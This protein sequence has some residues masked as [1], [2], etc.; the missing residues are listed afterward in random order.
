MFQICK[1]P[2]CLRDDAH[3]LNNESCK[4]LPSQPTLDKFLKVHLLC[5]KKKKKKKKKKMSLEY[6]EQKSWLH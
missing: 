3:N 6:L 1:K 2:F 5:C 4:A